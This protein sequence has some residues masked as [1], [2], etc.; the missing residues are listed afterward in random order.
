M[1]AVCLIGSPRGDGNTA[2]LVDH[3]IQGMQTRDIQVSRYC[4]GDLKIHYCLGCKNCYDT[5]LCIQRD[6]MDR[7]MQD[8]FESD[9]VLIAS[10]SYWGDVT[11]QLKVFFDRNTPFADTNPKRPP[12]TPGKVGA[13]IAIRAGQTPRENIHIIETIEHYFGHLGI[14]PVA[15]MTVESLETLNDLQNKTKSIE[16]AY[17]LGR[18]IPDLTNI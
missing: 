3:V 6:D 8:I 10:P 1:K 18:R 17:Q 2:Y 13:S 5:G 12:I 15:Q 4:L 9:I 11:G 16:A 14:K 7:I